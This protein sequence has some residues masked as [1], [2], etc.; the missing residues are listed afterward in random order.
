MSQLT[1]YEKRLSSCDASRGDTLGRR[2]QQE[3][4]PSQTGNLPRSSSVC[5]YS[6]REGTKTGQGVACLSKGEAVGGASACSDGIDPTKH[7]W[8]LWQGL[9]WARAHRSYFLDSFG[10]CG[11]GSGPCSSTPGS[12][13][14]A[15]AADYLELCLHKVGCGQ[16]ACSAE[17]P[18]ERLPADLRWE[19]VD[20]RPSFSAPY[21]TNL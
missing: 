8:P 5:W 3:E 2:L 7:E 1:N 12:F 19:V 14:Q 4:V 18:Q 13:L 21:G 16:A 10:L 11:G 17:N 9:V 20:E 15:P 6:A